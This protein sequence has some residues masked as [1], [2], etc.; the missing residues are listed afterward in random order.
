MP[1]SANGQDVIASACLSGIPQRM[2]IVHQLYDPPRD[3]ATLFAHVRKSA[4]VSI[5][6][7][8]KA[9]KGFNQHLRYFS[10]Y[11]FC[12]ALPGSGAS[13]AIREFSSSGC[14]EIRPALYALHG[15]VSILGITPAKNLP[16]V[17]PAFWNHMNSV[18]Q[19]SA[20]DQILLSARGSN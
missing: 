10:R 19:H 12:G 4:G 8:A 20:P 16:G 18:N 9:S 1:C 13:C 6:S 17:I 5:A 3:E 2:N 7:R 11:G 14:F 15:Y